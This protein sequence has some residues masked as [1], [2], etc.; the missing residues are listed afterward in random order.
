MPVVGDNIVLTRI[1]S[2]IRQ[3][4]TRYIV[5]QSLDSL[6]FIKSGGDSIKYSNVTLT[7]DDVDMFK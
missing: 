3:C 1:I 5:R 6:L 7:E 4:I 2:L